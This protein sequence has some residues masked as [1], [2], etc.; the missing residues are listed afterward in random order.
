MS[1]LSDLLVRRIAGDGPITVAEFMAESLTHPKHGYYMARDA[2]GVVGDFVTAP[3]IS[4]M[5]G[6]LIGLWCAVTWQVMGSPDTFNLIELGPGRGTLMADALRA[7]RVVPEFGQSANVHLVEVSP[8]FRAFQ[9]RALSESG[10]PQEPQWHGDLTAIPRGPSIVIA[11]EFFDA[12]PI[13]QFSRTAAGWREVLVDLAADGQSLRFVLSPPS[14]VAPMV[15]ESLRDAPVDS[16]VE[17]CPAGIGIARTIA[18]RAA[19]DGGAALIIDYGHLESGFGETLQAVRAHKFTD[20][21]GQPGLCDLTAHVD[22]AA[23]AEAARSGGARVHGP[24]TQSA[25][26]E[27]LGLRERGEALLSS[28]SPEQRDEIQSAYRRLVHP[29]EMG[30][31]FKVIGFCHPAMDA[32]HGFD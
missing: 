6:E 2:L 14:P 9:K 18:E 21:L 1:T 16:V 24:T 19:E 28:A 12:L 25:F 15:P 20:V 29:E 13:R 17:V 22:F 30:R 8:F 10:L 7:A 26:L 31:L 32:P 5:F 27:S 23:L 11:N 3:E 4:Q